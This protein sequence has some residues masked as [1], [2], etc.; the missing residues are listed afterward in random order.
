M[1]RGSSG[2]AM[3]VIGKSISEG[4]DRWK[5]SGRWRNEGRQS[6]NGGEWKV[7]IKVARNISI[8]NIINESSI[9]KA[10]GENNQARSGSAISGMV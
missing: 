3:E 4:E 10:S 5:A 6:V 8:S 7:V 2:S 9:I 1:K